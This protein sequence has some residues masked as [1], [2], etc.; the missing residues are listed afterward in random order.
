VAG[1]W[2]IDLGLD[3]EKIRL[4]PLEEITIVSNPGIGN[5]WETGIIQGFIFDY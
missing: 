1:S 3:K 4:T 2:K 5:I